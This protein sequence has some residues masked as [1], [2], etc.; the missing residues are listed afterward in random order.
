MKRIVFVIESLNLGGAERSLITLLQN[1]DYDR[2]HVDLITFS[3]KGFFEE[4]VPK[5]VNRIQLSFP[6]ITGFDRIKYG[7]KRKF[8]KNTHAAQLF[9]PIVSKYFRI[10]QQDYDIAIAYNQGFSTYFVNEKIVAKV[11]YAWLNVDYL[12]A[13]YRMDLDY[14]VYRNFNKV[15]VVSPEARDSFNK[16]LANLYEPLN[17]EIIK[18]I[19]DSNVIRQQANAPLKV[20]F[21]SEKVN[22]VSVGRLVPIKGF[23]LAIEACNILKNKSINICWYILGAGK[24]EKAL[25]TRIDSLGLSNEMHL[26]GADP[27]PYPYMKACDIYVQTSLFEGLGLTV[28]EATILQK[29]IVCTNFP[30]AFGILRNEESGLIA[31]MNPKSIADQIQRIIDEEGLRDK[32]VANLES[33]PNTDKEKILQKI[34]HLLNE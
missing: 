15:I 11:K 12:K 18:D 28:I 3:P 22:I 21:D 25:Q 7:I 31:E 13:G 33:R 16:A 8:S 5:Q 19:S 30:S 29:P 10:I 1:L 9:W 2:Y 20:N 26:L 34:G 6:E 14:P 24:A 32:L 17:I 27:N 23:D 4:F